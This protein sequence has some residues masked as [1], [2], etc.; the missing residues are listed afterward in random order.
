MGLWNVGWMLKELSDPATL[1]R[2]GEAL[3]SPWKFYWGLFAQSLPRPWQPP[4]TLALKAGGQFVVNNF[5]TLYIYKEIF[6]DHC[7]DFPA[8]PMRAPVI[9]D[10]GANTGLFAIRMKQLYPAA[11]LYCFEPA[12]ANY[13]ELT[14]NITLSRFANITSINKGVGGTARQEQLFLHAKNVGGHSLFQQA[15]GS[16]ASITIDLVDVDS[17][18]AMLDGAFCQLLKLD[19]EGA[20]YEILKSLTSAQARRL[21]RIIFEPTPA[22]YDPN[23]LR[24][25]LTD[26]GYHVEK[27]K[28][29][30]VALLP[31]A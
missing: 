12:P 15:A 13:H 7:Y 20:E 19:C 18:L 14:T 17:I 24:G 25:H 1:G 23:E 22:L 27:H 26:V 31:S 21:E 5:M 6:V 16:A 28:G 9:V 3:T 2:H 30:Y 8:L 11:S 10:V 4:L 29:L